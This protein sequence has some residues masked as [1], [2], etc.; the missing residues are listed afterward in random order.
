MVGEGG[1]VVGAL[2]AVGISVHGGGC[3]P[4]YRVNEPVFGGDGDGII[5]LRTHVIGA[6]FAGGQRTRHPLHAARC[7]ATRGRERGYPRAARRHRRIWPR[8]QHEVSPDSWNR[9]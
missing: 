6:Y 8:F 5:V 2:M 4:R 3:Q 1:V 7:A 9:R